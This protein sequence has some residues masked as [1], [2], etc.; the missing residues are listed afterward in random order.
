MRMGDSRNS[1]EGSR[2]R[3]YYIDL[4]YSDDEEAYRVAL[5]NGEVRAIE[6]RPDGDLVHLALYH[7]NANG[8]P[9]LEAQLVEKDCAALTIAIGE[10]FGWRSTG[11]GAAGG[12]S[13]E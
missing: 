4:A 2:R 10:C 1:E 5:A 8:K 7:R 6:V 3:R 12:G 9:T 11:W 13:D